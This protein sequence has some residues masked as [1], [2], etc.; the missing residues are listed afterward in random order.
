MYQRM[1]VNGEEVF[2]PNGMSQTSD[3]VASS[4]NLKDHAPMSFVERFVGRIDQHSY[5]KGWHAT[6]RFGT[7]IFFLTLFALSI[8]FVVGDNGLSY[9]TEFNLN[10]GFLTEGTVPPAI[11]QQQINTGYDQRFTVAGYLLALTTSQI[12]VAVFAFTVSLLSVW[13]YKYYSSNA[14][15][16]SDDASGFIGTFMTASQWLF[17]TPSMTNTSMW[18]NTED[19]IVTPWIWVGFLMMFGVRDIWFLVSFGCLGVARGLLFFSADAANGYDATDSDVVNEVKMPEGGFGI[20]TLRLLRRLHLSGFIGTYA[21]TVLGWLV[22][23]VYAA[24][25]PSEGRP[26]YYLGVFI[27][28]FVLELL[29]VVVIPSIY[30]GIIMRWSRWDYDGKTVVGLDVDRYNLLRLLTYTARFGVFFFCLRFGDTGHAFIP[31]WG[32]IV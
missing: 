30:Y 11:V 5:Y 9:Y 10:T 13:Q 22:M 27:T 12:A 7:S 15:E 4:T 3:A 20:R 17:S 6:V 25:F 14:S 16:Y 29:H 21:I 8:A 31:R 19:I 26:S 2:D 18:L 1:S 28:V 32:Y 24:K 23:W